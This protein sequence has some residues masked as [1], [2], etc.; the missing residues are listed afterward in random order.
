MEAAIQKHRAQLTKAEAAM[1]VVRVTLTADGSKRVGVRFPTQPEVLAA[2]QEA[3]AEAARC[4][5][6]VCI[7]CLCLCLRLF[8]VP[9]CRLCAFGTTS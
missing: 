6:C 2:L 1:R 4:V 9:G 3:I 7:L 8:C 5:G